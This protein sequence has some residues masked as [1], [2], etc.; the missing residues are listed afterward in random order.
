[1]NKNML[2]TI[3]TIVLLMFSALVV[4]AAVLVHLYKAYFLLVI[5]FVACIW[6]WVRAE[7]NK[8]DYL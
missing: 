3:V 2:A 4:M 5:L 1:M 8:K 7:I 6:L